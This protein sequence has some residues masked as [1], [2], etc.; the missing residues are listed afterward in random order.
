[1]RNYLIA[2]ILALSLTLAAIPTLADPA[3]DARLN[4][5]RDQWLSPAQITDKLV[6]AGYKVTEI[7]ADDGAY[8]VD[9]LDKNGIRVEGHVHPATGELLTGYDND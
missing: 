4:V 5:P 3:P 7:E 6:A 8:E 9:L 1:M 2:P